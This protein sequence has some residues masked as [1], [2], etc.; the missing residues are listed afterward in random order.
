LRH[1][2]LVAV[3]LRWV[4]NNR[5]D[6]VVRYV[7]TARHKEVAEGEPHKRGGPYNRL[8]RPL[9]PWLLATQA[10]GA[11]MDPETELFV[12]NAINEAKLEIAADAT[13]R[14]WVPA[15]HAAVMGGIATLVVMPLVYFGMDSLAEAAARQAADRAVEEKAAAWTE[16]FQELTNGAVVATQNTTDSATKA[17]RAESAAATARDAA[18]KTRHQ[19][20][21]ILG[22]GKSREELI[23]NIVK[24][25]AFA[26]LVGAALNQELQP[27][28]VPM[29]GLRVVAYGTVFEGNQAPEGSNN[30]KVARKGNEYAIA[31]LPPATRPPLV[32]LSGCQ[33]GVGKDLDQSAMDNVFTIKSATSEGFVVD[34]QDVEATAPDGTR[35]QP[36]SF[37]FVAL[38]W[39][40]KKQP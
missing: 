17:Q 9:G 29:N 32:L 10:R 16:V 30:W 18:E 20:D 31:I 22:D 15:R 19:I 33:P 2:L 36:A 34:S 26:E 38:G 4:Q 6:A 12:R 27:L 21:E 1:E 5:L 8:H 7:D 24:G 11:F 3:L 28:R 35:D 13:R 14:E 37:S 25:N 23:A 40:D 39:D